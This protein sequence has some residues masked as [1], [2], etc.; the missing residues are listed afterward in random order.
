L[1]PGR[2]AS[3]AWRGV[4]DRLTVVLDGLDNQML[5]LAAPAL[6]EWGLQRGVLGGIFALGFVGMALRYAGSRPDR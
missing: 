2:P 4:A 5:G 1:A 3:I 6:Q